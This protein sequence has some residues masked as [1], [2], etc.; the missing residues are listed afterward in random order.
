[1]VK[2]AK[3]FFNLIVWGVFVSQLQLVDYVNAINFWWGT[4]DQN[5]VWYSGTADNAA[6]QVIWNLLT[7]LYLVAVAYAL[8]GGFN[9]LTA[10]WDEEKVKKWKTI[11]IQW[12]IGLVV[13]WI[14]WALVQWVL[15]SVLTTGSTW[16]ATG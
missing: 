12:A 15:S 16:N 7:F 9:I 6:E 5:L 2:K 3:N 8:W 13:I 4:V 14:A 11:L 10:G 1:M